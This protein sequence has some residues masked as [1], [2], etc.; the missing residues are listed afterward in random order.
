MEGQTLTRRFEV[1]FGGSMLLACHGLQ[2]AADFIDGKEDGHKLSGASI[3]EVEGW[4]NLADGEF[5]VVN[6]LAEYEY[7]DTRQ[8]TLAL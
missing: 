8:G 6:V 1:W 4:M 7:P 2:V 5:Q 3:R